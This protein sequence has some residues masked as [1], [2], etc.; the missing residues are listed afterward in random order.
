MQHTKWPTRTPARTHTHSRTHLC[1]YAHAHAHAHARTHAL[2][3]TRMCT[4]AHSLNRDM[5]CL[6]GLRCQPVCCSCPGDG[7][8]GPVTPGGPKQVPLGPATVVEKLSKTDEI[9]VCQVIPRDGYRDRYRC[10]YRYERTVL[11]LASLARSSRT[12]AR[13][14]RQPRRCRSLFPSLMFDIIRLRW[15]LDAWIHTC[16]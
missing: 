3:Y 11:L 5:G 9:D 6:Q 14:R 1:T 4:R 15:R 2:M 13:H 16:E 12:N 7:E 8:F 10:G